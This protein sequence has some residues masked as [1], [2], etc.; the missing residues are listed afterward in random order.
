MNSKLRKILEE[1]SSE[2]SSHSW[3]ETDYDMLVTE[4]EKAIKQAVAEEMLELLGDD[5]VITTD[6][7]GID[8][9][10]KSAANY[11]L[12]ELR[13]KIKEWAATKE[14]SNE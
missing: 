2:S 8:L 7:T 6:D 14:T 12:M 5:A 11:V 10:R 4:A 9:A 13:Q 3:Q 1:L